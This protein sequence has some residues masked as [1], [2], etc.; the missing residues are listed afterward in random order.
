MLRSR[1]IREIV[2][3][4]PLTIIKECEG[5]YE[6]PVVGGQRVGP[7][8]GYAGTYEPGKH[9]VGDVYVNLAKV[10]QYPVVMAHFAKLL[11]QRAGVAGIDV[12][13]GAPMGGISFANM[14][15]YLNESRFVFAEKKATTLATTSSREETQL[16]LGRHEIQAG[17]R[18][19]IVEDVSNNFS[20]T[21]K[22]LQL[23]KEA[24]AEVTAILCVLNRSLTVDDEYIAKDDS[25]IP[26]I[27]LVR[28]KIMEYRQDDLAVAEDVA[29]GNVVW[30]PKPRDQ[31]ARLMKVMEAS[32]SN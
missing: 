22:L 17:D 2:L 1:Q 4:S 6:C 27:S 21:E 14:L 7:L 13:C 11:L 16:I 12:F 25:R 31:W 5:Y 3:H 8:V 18:V 32:K 23:I 26:V 29:S 9:F 20:T 15:A 28:Q 10:E 19:V 24:G 30:K